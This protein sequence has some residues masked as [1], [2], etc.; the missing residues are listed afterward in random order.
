MKMCH[1]EYES[2]WNFRN[3]SNEVNR[4]INPINPDFDYKHH[5]FP[6]SL[7]LKFVLKINFK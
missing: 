5:V 2:T 7:N 1:D 3:I 4:S 6:I